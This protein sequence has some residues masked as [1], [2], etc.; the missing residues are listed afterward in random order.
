MRGPLF[1]GITLGGSEPSKE[2]RERIA[3]L[4]RALDGALDVEVAADE[5]V[6]VRGRGKVGGGCGDAGNDLLARRLGQPNN[7]GGCGMPKF[8]YDTWAIASEDGT[9]LR[10]AVHVNRLDVRWE[11]TLSFDELVS[12]AEKM[13]GADRGTLADDGDDRWIELESGKRYVLELPYEYTK[14]WQ[15][16]ALPSERGIQLVTDRRIVTEVTFLTTH[17]R[18]QLRAKWGRPR[19]AAADDWVWYRGDR[20]IT[21]VFDGMK[22][23]VTIAKR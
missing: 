15:A 20:T 13:L 12:R 9:H 4:A 17:E 18:E 7:G 14:S 22:T 11:R 5:L 19:N 3:A 6:A 10:A 23:T 2:I 16:R 1:E 8:F 21:A